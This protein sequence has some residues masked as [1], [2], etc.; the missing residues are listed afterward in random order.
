MKQTS[1][2]GNQ[3][4]DPVLTNMFMYQDKPPDNIHSFAHL[5]GNE[6]L[7]VNDCFLRNMQK[8]KYIANIDNDEIFMPQNMT[9]LLDMMDVV[10]NLSQNEV[11]IQAKQS[12]WDCSEI[13]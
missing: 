11:D 2:A 13:T 9:S 6:R 7:S 3:P 1:L 5:I 4:N 8:F 10:E 12:I